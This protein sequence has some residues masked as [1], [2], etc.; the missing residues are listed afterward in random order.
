MSF[1]MISRAI[2]TV[3]FMAAYGLIFVQAQ[4]PNEYQLKAAIIY[5]FPKFVEWPSLAGSNPN[6]PIVI[7]I[8]GEDPFGREIDDVM[9]G[10]TAGGRRLV[11]K[12]F[13]RLK[14]LTPCH[15]LFVSS[16]Q[17]N[18]LKQIFDS[19]AGAGVLTV[20]ETDRFV[21]SG[22]VIHLNMSGGRVTLVINQA[23]A[24]RAGIRISAKLLG[25]ARVIRS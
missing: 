13:A 17:K 22:G 14:D 4:T 2:K 8:I 25:L 18:N 7:G 9:S 10:K 1:L 20:G 19:V 15:I 6:V 3:L 16:S 11:I 5:N 23:A 12:R 24:E 21:E